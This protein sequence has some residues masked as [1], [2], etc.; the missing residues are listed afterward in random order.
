MKET[1]RNGNVKVTCE[2]Q[3]KLFGKA[4]KASAFTMTNDPLDLVPFFSHIEQL[5][6]EL[7]IGYELKVKLLR[8][9]LNERANMFVARLDVTKSNDFV[10]VRVPVT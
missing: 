8:P 2:P 3:A 6:G 4:M 10:F 7:R 5:F 9:Y 1:G